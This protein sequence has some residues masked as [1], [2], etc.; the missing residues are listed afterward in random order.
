MKLILFSFIL[1]LSAPSYSQAP[2]VL[3]FEQL[4]EKWSKSNDTLYVINYWATWCIPC[5]KELPDFIKLDQEMKTEK[6]KMILVS[7]DFPSQAD[8]R[9]LPFIQKNNITSEVIIL[10]D[11]ANV[12]I[13]K[14]NKSWDGDIPATQFI[15]NNNKE[16]YNEQLSHERLLQIVNKYS[17]PKNK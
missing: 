11:D 8:S 10:D 1:L 5:I 2:E 13:D 15:Q 14:V 17:E 6:F 7:L 3:D 9:V 16:F 4:E 12:W